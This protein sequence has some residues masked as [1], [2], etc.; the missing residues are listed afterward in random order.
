MAL[1]KANSALVFTSLKGPCQNVGFITANE[2]TVGNLLNPK[3]IHRGW[4]IIHKLTQAGCQNVILKLQV[5]V[6]S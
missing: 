1:Y 3:S 4:G 5:Q 6:P 2:F